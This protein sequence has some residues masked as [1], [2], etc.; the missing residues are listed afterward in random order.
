MN[1]AAK[2]ESKPYTLF[3]LTALLLFIFSFATLGDKFDFHIKDTY[4]VT[5]TIYSIWLLAIIFW[6][7]WT[8]YLLLYKI[9]WKKFL[10]WFHVVTTLLSLV[11]LLTSSLWFERTATMSRRDSYDYQS[12]SKINQH[13][14]IIGLILLLT[15]FIG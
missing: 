7:A 9:L 12:F 6:F 13:N 10:T 4:I 11:L 8:V 14:S 15:F 1:L 3:L 2:I 5:A